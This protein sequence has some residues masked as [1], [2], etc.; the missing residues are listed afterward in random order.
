[1]S[2]A[3]FI[4]L[5]TQKGMI[6]S[7][8]KDLDKDTKQGLFESYVDSRSD[9]TDEQKAYTKENILF[10][11]MVPAD[12]SAY[13]K[14]VEAGYT[15]P[16]EIQALHEERRN[17]DLDGDGSY[18]SKAEILH[19]IS[20]TTDD[21]EE[22]EKKWNALKEKGE[23]RTYA[24]LEKEYRSQVTAIQTAKTN[25]DEKVPAETQSAF[26]AAISDAGADSQKEIKKALQSVDATE[27]ERIA[28]YELVKV[29]QGWKKSWHNIR[30]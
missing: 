6:D 9:L 24:Q 2:A 18:T 1:M 30:M 8:N 14:A 10:F 23:E 4:E 27:E 12:S 3:K 11:S 5:Y 16:K 26:A 19:Y 15:D 28:Y 29:K 17:Y 7:A 21:P 20:S 13:N 25:L 22:Q